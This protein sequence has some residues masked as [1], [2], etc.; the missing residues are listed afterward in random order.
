V[1]TSNSKES[2]ITTSISSIYQTAIET[3]IGS[4]N[5][6][7]LRNVGVCFALTTRDQHVTDRILGRKIDMV[8]LFKAARKVIRDNICL[9][10]YAVYCKHSAIVVR[11]EFGNL[12]FRSYYDTRRNGYMIKLCSVTPLT[13]GHSR[14]FILTDGGK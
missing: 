3:Y 4:L 7:T 13:F 8:S 2:N 10:V 9:L 6:I 11:T 12:V 14:D 1:Y 5:S